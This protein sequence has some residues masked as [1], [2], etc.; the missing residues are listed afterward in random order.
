M[1][2]L[3]LSHIS[4]KGS[5]IDMAL[6]PFPLTRPHKRVQTYPK[7]YFL[8]EGEKTEKYYILA[9][10]KLD[11]FHNIP[12]VDIEFLDKIDADKHVSHVYKLVDKAVEFK[13]RLPLFDN[14]KDRIYI[15][16][17][18]DVFR[19]DAYEH[20]KKMKQIM[21]KY[22]FIK[23]GY[24]HPAFELYL[25]MHKENAYKKYILP[26]KGKIINNEWVNK[27]RY[28]NNLTSNVLKINPKKEDHYEFLVPKYLIA[29][30]NCKNLNHKLEKFK[31]EL[32]CNLD[33]IFEELLKLN[34]D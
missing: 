10:F 20:I 3:G 32:T 25:L 29:L 2:V 14:K 13:S 12:N 26:N 18:L 8:M 17:D 6:A 27:K 16:Y 9:I 30:E 22:P 23:F 34:E 7:I 19:E 15:F 21:R 5:M 11:E 4:L 33:D 31:N 28:I 1:G 24:T